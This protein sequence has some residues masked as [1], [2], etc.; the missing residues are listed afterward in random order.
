[1]LVC[2][3][4]SNKLALVEWIDVEQIVTDIETCDTNP[5]PVS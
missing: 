5:N 4:L 2:V 1:M 3:I